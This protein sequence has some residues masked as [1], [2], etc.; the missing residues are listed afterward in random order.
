MMSGDI[1]ILVG[2]DQRTE[3]YAAIAEKAKGLPM[4]ILR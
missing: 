2:D 4:V 3:S 1:P